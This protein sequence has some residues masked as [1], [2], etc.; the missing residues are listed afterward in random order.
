MEADIRKLIGINDKYQFISELFGND[1]E[2]YEI[3]LTRLNKFGS[4]ADAVTWMDEVHT[5]NR[6]DDEHPTVISFYDVMSQF[7]ASR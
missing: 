6:W 7:F 1:K 5:E 4:Y 2:T 3:V